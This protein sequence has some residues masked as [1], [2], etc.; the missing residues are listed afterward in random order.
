MRIAAE[1]AVDR[2]DQNPRSLQRVHYQAQLVFDQTRY[3]GNHPRHVLVGLVVAPSIADERELLLTDPSLAEMMGG[4]HIGLRELAEPVI[5][6]N[7]NRGAVAVKTHATARAGITAL[8]PQKLVCEPGELRYVVE[9]ARQYQM[10]VMCHA[11]GSEGCRLAVEAGVASLEHG[12]FADEPTLES[13]ARRGTWLV[14]TLSVLHDM[15][16]GGGEYADPQ[17]RERGKRM[18][19]AACNTV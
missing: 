18:F 1:V 2:R 7:A 8:D 6:L 15:A 10:P 9:V 19:D 11:H 17:L 12:T 3:I 4:G 16:F 5:A 14:P 13:M